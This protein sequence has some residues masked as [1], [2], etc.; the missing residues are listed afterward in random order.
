[1]SRIKHLSNTPKTCFKKFGYF[2]ATCWLL[3]LAFAFV[4]FAKNENEWLIPVETKWKKQN[5]GKPY[6][7]QRVKKPRRKKSDSMRFEIRRGESWTSGDKLVSFRTEVNTN[8]H[9]PMNSENWYGFSIQLPNDFPIE[10]NRLVLAQWW[11][12]NKENLGEVLKAPPLQLRYADGRMSIRLR[13]SRLRVVK[14]PEAYTE[15]KLFETR[16]FRHGQWNDFVF[17]VKWAFNDG[18]INVWLNGEQVVEYKGQTTYDD[19]IGPKFKFGLYRD[20]SKETYVS[21]MSEVR[22]GK[23]LGEVNPAADR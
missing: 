21:F 23:S 14:D 7:L 6:S 8:Q 9:V 1:M 18:F 13:T 15:N 3:Q 16:K 2:V 10:N 12:L 17:Q 22:Q 4:S 5:P 11:A 19:E 20:D